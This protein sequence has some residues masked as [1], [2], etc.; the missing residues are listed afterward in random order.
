MLPFKLDNQEISH[1][2][3]IPSF[4]SQDDV[5]MRGQSEYLADNLVLRWFKENKI[6]LLD[7]AKSGMRFAELPF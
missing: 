5:D 7:F 3:V 4:L 1:H 6:V 2:S